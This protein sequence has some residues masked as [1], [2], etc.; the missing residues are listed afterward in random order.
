MLQKGDKAPEFSLFDTEKKEVKLSD[1][2]GKN[3]L[4]L[5]FPLAF[6]GTCTAELCST[7]DD[8]G[9]YEN[10]GVNILIVGVPLVDGDWDMSWLLKQAG[11]LNGT[12]FP[13]WEGNSALTGHVY[14]SNG[15]PGPFVGLGKLKWGDKIFVH[16]Y[17]SVYTYEV[18]ENRTVSPTSISVLKHEADS[19]LTLIT[20][21]TYNE[22]TN[23]YASRIAVRATLVN[24][25]KDKL[26]NIPK[27]GR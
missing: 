20:C 15:K 3:V 9:F 7:R 13:G 11:W 2:A 24:V 4:I 8:I 1:Y 5:F 14:L 18:R 23:T 16:A 22:A 10:L 17:G 6:T 19:W 12:A 26:E 25:Q 21:K 27:N